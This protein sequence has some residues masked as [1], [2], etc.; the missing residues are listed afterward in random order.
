[1]NVIKMYLDSGSSMYIYVDDQEKNLAPAK[2]LGWW[3]SLQIK[4]ANGSTR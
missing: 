2:E 1:M 4:M 3:R